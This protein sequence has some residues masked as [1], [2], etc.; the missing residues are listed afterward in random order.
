MSFG[1]HFFEAVNQL[2]LLQYFDRRTHAAMGSCAGWRAGASRPRSSASC[3][4][5]LP[6]TSMFL[7]AGVLC[8]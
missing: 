6:Y 2:L 7:I 5:F 4:G 3:S 8:A 1:F